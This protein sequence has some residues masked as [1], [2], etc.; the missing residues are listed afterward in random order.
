MPTRFCLLDAYNVRHGESKVKSPKGMAVVVPCL[1][2]WWRWKLLLSRRHC[3]ISGCR[4]F[5]YAHRHP[6]LLTVPFHRRVS[7]QRG[8]G[9][10]RRPRRR[11]KVEV[12]VDTQR[13]VV[14]RGIPGGVGRTAMAGSRNVRRPVE[15][16][17]RRQLTACGCGDSLL[18]LAHRPE[19]RPLLF[20]T[21][22]VLS[23]KITH[24][25]SENSGK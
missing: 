18:A 17:Q 25:G 13:Y 6:G 5:L 22:R 16:V 20:W 8:G 10:W 9:G 3:K 14:Y 11:A 19:K 12:V 23:A 4:C 15:V 1:R 21:V 7:S 2:G 24:I